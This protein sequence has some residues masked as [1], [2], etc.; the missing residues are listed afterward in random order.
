V[1][2]T[3]EPGQG[4]AANIRVVSAL[5][6]DEPMVT[7]YLRV[8]CG[9]KSNRRYV[10][11]ADFPSDQ[12]VQVPQITASTSSTSPSSSPGSAVATAD[13]V[14]AAQVAPGVNASTPSAITKPAAPVKSKTG[15]AKKRVAKSS[16]TRKNALTAPAKPEASEPV[17]KPDPKVSAPAG[18]SPAAAKADAP[19]DANQPRL[20]LDPLV[21]LAER[22]ATL[23][24]VASALT[25]VDFSK[26]VQ[27]VETL[28]S[29]VKTLVALA[30]KNEAS[31]LEMRVQLQKAESERVPL[32]WLYALSALLLL[33]LGAIAWLWNRQRM[34]ASAAAEK[35]KEDWWGNSKMAGLGSA[36]VSNA[37]VVPQPQAAAQ[38]ELRQSPILRD[39]TADP[40][41]D[42][43][44]V[45][46]SESNFDNLMQ[47][48]EAHSALRK[49]PLASQSV[50]TPTRAQRLDLNRTI[51]SDQ[52]FDVRQQAEFF[53]TLGQTDQAVRVL[54]SRINESGECSPLL[55]LDLLKIFHSLNL[56]QDYH[57]FREDFNLLFSSRMPEFADYGNEGRSLE[58]YPEALSRIAASWH[59]PKAVA[60]I[61]A[62]IFKEALE[63]SGRVFDLAAF[64]D[65]LLLHA[66][67]QSTST[68]ELADSSAPSTPLSTP[69][70]AAPDIATGYASN[71]DVDLSQLAK[72]AT[73]SGEHL[74][75][76]VTDF[77]TIPAVPSATPGGAA[78]GEPA[79][80]QPGV[81]E[82]NFLNFDQHL[83][84]KYELPK[85]KA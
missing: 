56:K 62:S 68:S 38:A 35:D 15:V 83:T 67:A 45:E 29:S 24:S 64:R 1:R 2:V 54:E 49:G 59:T 48:G 71:I 46:M 74:S 32:G 7:V 61:E 69:Q 20:K 30:S 39:E 47:S 84:D 75:E 85:G 53:V 33:C 14:G 81:E 70:S 80:L 9:Q 66:I 78:F 21:T 17:E 79:K 6:V 65:L 60:M 63:G 19:R 76:S 11:L 44:L 72:L 31:M 51:N 25:A 28:E 26:E 4:N 10:L 12:M 57:Q 58:D 16:A 37:G 55:Y 41:M 8:G 27:R 18:K 50:P 13:G 73:A 40:D 23:E 82:N 22:V 3:V 5:P 52:V 36:P 77:P 34:S 42:V 43:S